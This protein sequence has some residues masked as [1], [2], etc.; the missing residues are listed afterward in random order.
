MR[1]R[2]GCHIAE[3]D[4]GRLLA[5]TKAPRVAEFVEL[6]SCQVFVALG[7]SRKRAIVDNAVNSTAFGDLEQDDR[8]MLA[9]AES[10]TN[11]LMRMRQLIRLGN[12]GTEFPLELVP[13]HRMVLHAVDAVSCSGFIGVFKPQCDDPAFGICKRNDRLQ[14]FVDFPDPFAFEG[15]RLGAQQESLDQ[16]VVF[17]RECNF[18]H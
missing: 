12:P 9:I 17:R 14:E 10:A 13:I 4:V 15:V 16:I 7:Q 1:T 2:P 5:P 11:L 6:G 3:L 8:A 18:F